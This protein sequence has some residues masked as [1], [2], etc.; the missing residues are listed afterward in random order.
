M[1]RPNTSR[2]CPHCASPFQV[3]S[4]E[5]ESPLLS[6]IHYQCINAECGFTAQGFFELKYE[7][8]PSGMPNP[9]IS[10]P[11][12]PFRQKHKEVASV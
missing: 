1:A 11:P 4:S 7:L 8:S 6:R 3:R 10:L 2:K 12:S 5:Q 9:E